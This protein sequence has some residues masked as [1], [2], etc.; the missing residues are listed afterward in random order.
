MVDRESPAWLTG[1][2]GVPHRATPTAKTSQLGRIIRVLPLLPLCWQRLMMIGLTLPPLPAMGQPRPPRG[3]VN[4]PIGGNDSR[5][6]LSR[7]ETSM[8]QW[9]PSPALNLLAQDGGFGAFFQDQYTLVAI[10][11]IFL[12]AYFMLIRPEQ[13]K[14]A[15][16]R[17]ML[18]ELKRN[19][20]VETIGGILGTIVSIK[21]DQGEVVLRVDDKTGAEIRVRL[22]AILGA[23][24]KTNKS[25]SAESAKQPE[26][27][28]SGD[29]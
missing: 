15:E 18:E 23:V 10:S 28:P 5:K 16:A 8:P 11:A 29:A 17:K 26:K 7:N 4:R 12:L 27:S 24:D 22:R 19:D 9:L 13:R 20:R 25:A 1:E 2:F 21:K 3:S 14:Q 6:S